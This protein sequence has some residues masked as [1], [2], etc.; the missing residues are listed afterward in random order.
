R[1]ASVLC[2][3]DA[4]VLDPATIADA[5]RTHPTMIDDGDPVPSGSY[6]DPVATAQAVN[7]PLPRPPA[8]A[9]RLSYSR[10]GDLAGVR[11]FVR[12]RAETLLSA[13]R[14]HALVLAVHELAA[15]TIKHAGGP[16]R[17]T[18]WT[19]AGLI[20]CQVEDRGHIAD[21][22]AGRRPPPRTG[23]T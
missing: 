19:G 17:L 13:E 5:W 18:M 20:A 22:L 15:N 9:A 11:S 23:M 12:E 10:A 1:A 2:P 4:S 3:Y 16:G 14:A 7:V 8:E 6:G 21:P